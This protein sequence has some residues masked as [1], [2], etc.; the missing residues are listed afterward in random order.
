MEEL[1][2]LERSEGL[3]FWS[4][5]GF[6]LHLQF[7]KCWAD[8][9]PAEWWDQT[10]HLLPADG[11]VWVAGEKYP[12]AS[13]CLN[14]VSVLTLPE[15]VPMF[16]QCF[17]SSLLTIAWM[18][19]EGW[20][21]CSQQST[22]QSSCSDGEILRTAPMALLDGFHSLIHSLLVTI[23]LVKIQ[24]PVLPCILM[25]SHLPGSVISSKKSLAWLEKELS[26][27]LLRRKQCLPD[28]LKFYCFDQTRSKQSQKKKERNKLCSWKL[29]QLL[30]LLQTNVKSGCVVRT[31]SC[32][33]LPQL[34]KFSWVVG[35]NVKTSGEMEKKR[36][37]KGKMCLGRD[38][39][40][41]WSKI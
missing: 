13:L 2:M 7:F 15:C 18:Q 36:R 33:V 40:L 5:E 21:S 26:T 39:Q 10:A 35:K 30:S 34:K 19:G 29:H 22:R 31:E 23:N 17:S 11:L 28:F 12:K 20:A 6:I 4:I 38:I 3:S 9:C 24:F 41:Q 37:Q 32:T 8:P 1:G 16:S 14:L 25:L 27:V